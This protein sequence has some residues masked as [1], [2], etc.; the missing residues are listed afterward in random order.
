MGDVGA[1]AETGPDHFDEFVRR[2]RLAQCARNIERGTDWTA[3]DDHNRDV[4]KVRLRG[5]L[6]VDDVAAD[7][8]ES[9]VEHDQ[10]RR[11]D[12][13]QMQRLQAITRLFDA[14]FERQGH[15]EHSSEVD[16]ILDEE[17]GL[18]QHAE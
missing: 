17:Y 9:E 1:G 2:E 18:S 8:G 15:P 13:Q 14:I 7:E 5:D 6:L 11:L 4:P 10:I 12:V 3:G 16:V